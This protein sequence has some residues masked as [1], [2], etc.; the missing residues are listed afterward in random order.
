MITLYFDC[1]AGISGDMTVGALLDLG[2]P[3][4]H[5]RKEL[6]ALELPPGSYTLSTSRTE[7][8]QIPAL[9][10]DVAV[11]DHHTH[12]HYSRIDAMI[13]ASGLSDQVK[14]KSRLIF[15]CLAEAEAKVHGVAIENVHFHEVG[16]IDSIVDIVATAI[17]LEHLQVEQIYASALPLGSGFVETAHGRLSVPA[18]AT[19]ELLKGLP[20]H[21][22]CG[23]GERVTPTGA[24][25]LVALVSGFGQQPTMLLEKTGCGA[26]GRDFTDCP[27]ILRA[28]L[29]SK[30][31]KSDHADEV[32]VVEANIDDSTPEVL[33][34]AMERLL[35][36]GALDVFFASIQM[37]KNRP[38][39][40]VSF[41]CHPEQLELLSQTLLVETTAIGLRYYRADR[42]IL[43]RRVV[44]RQTDFGPVR[45]KEIIDS[46]GKMLRRSP[47]YEDCRR[48]AREK[49]IPCREV[50]ERL[51]YI[52]VSEA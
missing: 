31:E 8:L 9:K 11:H 19:A 15:R 20:V 49:E 52:G 50:M 33:G 3:L 23:S 28:F 43:Q 6:S 38:G 4:E 5:V 45:F 14:E 27:N 35:E 37:K 13:A 2:V 17:C 30:V 22:E 7:R 21:G 29:G 39:V 24:A 36:E 46:S 47:E 48:I 25:I 44:E 12:R 18:P 40:M 10:F 26:G 51:Q 1:Y 32:I 34:Y 16:A 42:I 41:L